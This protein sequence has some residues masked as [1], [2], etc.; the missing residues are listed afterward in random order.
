M[1]GEL[2]AS[3]CSNKRLLMPPESPV[4]APLAASGAVRRVKH[5]VAA[6]KPVEPTIIRTNR[7]N[8]KITPQGE[9]EGLWG[10][11]GL[12]RRELMSARETRKLCGFRD[13]SHFAYHRHKDFPAPALRFPGKQAAEY[14]SK[15]DVKAWLAEREKGD[16]DA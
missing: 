9:I 16:A 1:L 6:S 11:K 8:L 13:R 10:P 15:S 7:G 12:V 5:R 14:W 2:V 4:P 3:L